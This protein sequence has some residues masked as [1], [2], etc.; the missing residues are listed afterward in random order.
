MTRAGLQ[1]LPSPSYRTLRLQGGYSEV[2]HA[3]HKGT[4][5]TRA[6]K[7]VALD[8]PELLPGDVS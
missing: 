6:L 7:V 8:D 5:E 2:W 4:G 3:V 1:H